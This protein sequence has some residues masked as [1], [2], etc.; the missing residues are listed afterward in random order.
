MRGPAPRSYVP[1]TG[2]HA[3]TAFRFSK[4]TLRSTAKS[5]T[6]GNLV[7]GSTRIGC[8][9]WS[10]RAE[11]AMRALLLMTMAHDPHTSS[12]QFASYVMGEV[13]TPAV[14]TGLVAISIRLEIT[15]MPGFQRI[16]KLSHCAGELG[17]A[18]RLILKTTVF[19]RVAVFAAFST[20]MLDPSPCA[21]LLTSPMAI[22]PRHSDG[23]A[24]APGRHRPVRI[25]SGV[26]RH[27]ERKKPWWS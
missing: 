13:V 18:W 9:S 27:P 21:P 6:T 4:I 7:S 1:S 23:D 15:F 16:S 14:V 10:T 17:S 24:V 20:D 12:R 25:G 22:S 8:S 2:T 11:Q 26:R 5:R 19:G 3:F